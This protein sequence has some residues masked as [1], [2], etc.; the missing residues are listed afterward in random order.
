MAS[1]KPTEEECEE[2]LLSC[3]YGELEEIKLFVEQ[4][5]VESLPNIMDENMN[6]VL[7]MTCGNGHLGV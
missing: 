4:F 6:T 1:R 7:H 2:L 5:G 3:R